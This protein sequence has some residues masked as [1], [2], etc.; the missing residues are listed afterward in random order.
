MTGGKHEE[1]DTRLLGVLA[2]MWSPP[3]Y[4]SEALVFQVTYS[5]SQKKIQLDLG[6]TDDTGIYHKPNS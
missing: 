6:E 2:K 5:M 1:S 4:N 3:K